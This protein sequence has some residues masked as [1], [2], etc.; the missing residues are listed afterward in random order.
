MHFTIMKFG[1]A[2]NLGRDQRM[3][4]LKNNK[5]VF[6]RSGLKFLNNYTAY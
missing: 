2:K 5:S 3:T 4:S 1:E 6:F